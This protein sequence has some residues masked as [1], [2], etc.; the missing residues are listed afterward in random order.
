MITGDNK[1][2]ADACKFGGQLQRFLLSRSLDDDIAQSSSSVFV[3]LI[4]DLLPAGPDDGSDSRAG[5][6]WMTADGDDVRARTDG[7]RKKKA[8]E[9]ADPNHGYHIPRL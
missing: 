5:R 8:S 4:Y 6:K 7:D 9:K 1:A 2:P 3:H